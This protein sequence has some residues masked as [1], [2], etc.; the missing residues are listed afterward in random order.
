MPLHT[1]LIEPRFVGKLQVPLARRRWSYGAC[2]AGQWEQT[3]QKSDA[4]R[5]VRVAFPEEGTAQSPVLLAVLLL[6]VVLGGLLRTTHLT[7]DL[8][9]VCERACFTCP[10]HPE[11]AQGRGKRFHVAAVAIV[12]VQMNNSIVAHQ[13][14]TPTA[15]SRASGG[16]GA[17]A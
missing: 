15:A 14:H 16:G 11:A 7:R 8:A 2:Q 4:V 10:L 5:V 6:L 9:F 1:D 17:A 12:A 3:S 13:I